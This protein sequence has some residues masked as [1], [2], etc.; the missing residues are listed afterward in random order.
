MVIPDAQTA[1]PLAETEKSPSHIL[2]T[3]ASGFIG[4]A[5]VDYLVQRGHA[6]TA[7]SRTPGTGNLVKTIP[8]NEYTDIHRLSNIFRGQDTVIHL[9]ALAHRQ[10]PGNPQEVATAFAA[11]V[12]AT[13]AVAKAC[14]AAGVRRLVLVSSIGVNGN[15]TKRHPLTEGGAPQPGEPY[16]VGKF[17]CE[18]ALRQ[19]IGRNPSLE[20]VIIRPPLVYG[21]Q[22]PGNFG[23][24]LHAVKSRKWLPFGRVNNL[25]S[26]IGLDNLLH[27]IELC[28]RHPAAR[29][30][31]YLVSDGEDV[32]TPGLIRRIATALRQPDRLLNLP[33]PVLRLIAGLAGRGDQI[34]RL[35]SSLQVDSTKARTQLGWAPPVSLDEGLASAV[36]DT[37][38][39]KPPT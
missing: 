9:A 1:S 30:Q 38:S 16:P 5:L 37:K 36:R 26:L 15:R 24:L 19:V 17:E 34:D 8:I 29:N 14:V 23:K 12:S 21:P 11:N 20:F 10:V 28:A 27:F 4:R 2:V 22:A 25:R 18:V 35:V 3:G 6:V 33:L 13:D 32:S 39:S 7:V 31:I